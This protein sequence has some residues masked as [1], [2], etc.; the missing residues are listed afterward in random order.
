[1]V[2]YAIARSLRC[3]T[4][5]HSIAPVRG[6]GTKGLRLRL[7]GLPAAILAATALGFLPRGAMTLRDPLY[8]PLLSAGRKALAVRRQNRFLAGKGLPATQRHVDIDGVQLDR[9]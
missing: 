9:V 8:T 3:T 2:Q 7:P 6:G 5:G 4:C 1:M